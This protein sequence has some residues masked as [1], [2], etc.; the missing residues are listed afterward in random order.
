MVVVVLRLISHLLT[1]YMNPS[2][3]TFGSPHPEE[4]TM[5]V[6]SAAI[7]VLA[8][9]VPPELAWALGRGAKGA[10][11]FPALVVVLYCTGGFRQPLVRCDISSVEAGP[12]VEPL[13]ALLMPPPLP[14][15]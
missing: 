5:G 6:S 4:L 2:V 3:M 15:H 8:H 12:T 11:L 14:W 1:L 7:T 13:E 9:D 10:A